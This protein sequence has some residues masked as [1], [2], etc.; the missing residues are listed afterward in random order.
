M[1][2]LSIVC[3]LWIKSGPLVLI[4]VHLPDTFSSWVVVK[5]N[6][7]IKE[8]TGKSQPF[9][10]DPPNTDYFWHDLS[11]ALGPLSV[12]LWT[13]AK[14]PV[15]LFDVDTAYVERALAPAGG[16]HSLQDFSSDVHWMSKLLSLCLGL[17]SYKLGLLQ[18]HTQIQFTCL[19]G[20]K[21]SEKHV[22]QLI[23]KDNAK[24][25]WRYVLQ[26]LHMFGYLEALQNCPP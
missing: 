5:W 10:W 18:L 25:Q 1:L 26:E 13:L 17:T 16:W 11:P 8:D 14:H 22:N 21:N 20:S 6:D 12:L 7:A 15:F 2:T 19:S 9:L 4:T 3:N 24:T 23:P